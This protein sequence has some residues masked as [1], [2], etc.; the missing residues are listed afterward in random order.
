MI[1]LSAS[2]KLRC[3]RATVCEPTVD[4]VLGEVL[5]ILKNNN[6]ARA[7]MANTVEL[8]FLSMAKALYGRASETERELF[9]GGYCTCNSFA[10]HL[11]ILASVSCDEGSIRLVGGASD[12]EG[13][14]EVCLDQAWGTVTD[15]F[16][17]L[18]DARVVCRQLGHD[19]TSEC[20]T[21][22]HFCSNYCSI[23]QI[24]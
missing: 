15:F 1:R 21:N 14:L 2:L 18:P 6:V 9:I 17:N 10:Y 5:V 24:K 7:P 19:D 13:R 4:V 12:L 22:L 11:F 8:P 16:F 20:C 23:Y 3:L